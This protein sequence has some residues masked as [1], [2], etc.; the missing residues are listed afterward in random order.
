M[1]WFLV[2]RPPTSVD[3]RLQHR[4]AVYRS[5]YEEPQGYVELFKVY[6]ERDVLVHLVQLI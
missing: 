2:Q 4:Y 1:H 5:V 6:A 3:Y